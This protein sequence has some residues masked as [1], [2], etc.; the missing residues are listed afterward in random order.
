MKKKDNVSLFKK[1]YQGGFAMYYAVAG[2]NGFAVYESYADAERNR[3][4]LI[5]SAIKGFLDV[6]EA[7]TYAS[8]IYNRYQ[9]F[10]DDG[11][12]F[13]DFCSESDLNW[14]FFKKDIQKRNEEDYI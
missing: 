4:Y 11:I 1:R 2:S 14:M 7:F 9:S 13:Y 5:K 3:K 10:S 12:P 8:D 6:N